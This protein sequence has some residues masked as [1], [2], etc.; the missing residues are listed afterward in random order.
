MLA[1]K[2]YRRQCLDRLREDRFHR[3]TSAARPRPEGVTFKQIP[4]DIK[5]G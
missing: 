3:L 1:L 4:Y 2:N 5:V